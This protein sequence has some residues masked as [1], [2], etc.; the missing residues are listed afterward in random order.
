MTTQDDT[1]KHASRVNNPAVGQT[2]DWSAVLAEILRD[3]R[4]TRSAVEAMGKQLGEIKEKI[5][6]QE[7]QSDESKGIPVRV[8]LM[9]AQID[10]LK[11][12]TYGAV[13]LI[14]IAVFGGIIGLVVKSSGN[15]SN[16]STHQTRDL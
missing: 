8:A 1:G 5:A 14:L 7:S 12:I 9:E 6:V 16:Q 2:P 4:Q 3:G 11:L 10:T 13:G 15:Q